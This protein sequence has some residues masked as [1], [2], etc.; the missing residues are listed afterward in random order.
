MNEGPRA[1][2]RND[3]I[4]IVGGG[5]AGIHAAWALEER[6]FTNV[7]VFE[8]D[9]RVGGKSLTV[10]DA[11]GIPHEMGTCY[12]HPAYAEIKR[13]LEL[14]GATDEVKP[15]GPDGDR[16]LYSAE[17]TGTLDR[18]LKLGDWMLGA[19]EQASFP[20]FLW[21]APDQLQAGNLVLAIQRY[22]LLHRRIFGRYEGSLPPRPDD[23]GM[24]HLNCTMGQ[25]LRNH[26]LE[27]L[28]PLLTLSHS[29]MGYGLIETIPA[30][31]GLWWNTPAVLDA[32][33]ASGRDPEK[34][35]LTMLSDGFSA[36]WE[37]MATR[38][39][40]V[41]GSNVT[42]IV[43]NPDGV[44]ISGERGGEE[45]T[46]RADWVVVTINL[47]EALRV[48]DEDAEERLLFGGMRAATLVTH[49]VEVH[50]RESECITYWPDRLKVGL[51]G[52]LYSV[53]D[54]RKCL[55]PGEPP[56]DGKDVLVTY[57]YFDYRVRR[58]KARW[59]ERMLR[60]DL[61]DAGYTGVKV[62]KRNIWPYFNRFTQDGINRGY[63]WALFE[64]QGVNRTWY[65]G[66][67]ACFESVHDITM[68]T[69]QVLDHVLGEGE[70][71]QAAD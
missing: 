22:K 55:R 69:Q 6:G 50:H 8:R 16:D 53:R 4:A 60:E 59:V 57:Q 7:V 70:E 1:P 62:L 47:R 18:P 52:R 23:D 10:R 29:V 68:Y 28:R 58:R 54:G 67:S 71:Q 64:R 31:Y 61:E 46:E 24:K 36:L 26:N 33:L 40:V 49:L 2:Q 15:G 9:E 38:V 3:R 34:P 5:P 12:L 27:A 45:F 25:F 51:D 66:G 35:V 19:I 14:T 39:D 11:N 21:W 37:K 42:D 43:R 20:K 56:T 48:L 32:F 65:L 17:L 44:E 30:L 41:L 13:L 63:P